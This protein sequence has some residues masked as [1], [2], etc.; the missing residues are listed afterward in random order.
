MSHRTERS[1]GGPNRLG[2]LAARPLMA[3]ALLAAGLN[4]AFATGGLW[5]NADD[6]SV[7]FGIRSGMTR[8][9]GPGRGFF[10]FSAELAIA[11]TLV[12]KDLRHLR[13]NENNLHQ[14]WLSARELKLDLFY[15]GARN[16]HDVDVELL[17]ETTRSKE[18]VYLGTYELTVV[19]PRVQ[20]YG[21]PL[22]L[23]GKAS[24]GAD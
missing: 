19:D 11:Q 8:L 22:D 14:N 2:S 6:Q 7:Q 20:G 23:H 10:N 16:A 13:M 18:G 4:S 9:R 15:R 3:A 5:C 12:S 21:E 1:L 17:I 24:C